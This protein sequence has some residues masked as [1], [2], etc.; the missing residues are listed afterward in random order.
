MTAVHEETARQRALDVYHVVDSLPDTAFDDIGRIASILCAAPIALVSLIDRDRQW[1]KARTGFELSETRR[2][3][4]FCDHAIRTPGALMEVPDAVD[5]ARFA[6]NP[7]VTGSTGIRFYAGMPLITPSGAA[8]GT[9]C[10]LDREPRTLSDAQRE[11]LAS[12]ARLTMN[13]LE[14]RHR[15]RALE[16]SIWLASPAD[17]DEPE[18]AP[19]VRS[20]GRTIVIFEVQGLADAVA[21]LGERHVERAFLGL[22]KTLESSLRS[23]TGDNLSRATGSPEFIVVLQGDAREDTLRSLREVVHAFA[24]ESALALASGSATSESGEES[25]E[26]LFLRADADLS[27]DKDAYRRT[28]QSG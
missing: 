15:E 23:G 8:I 26:E 27:L 24:A 6:T 4:A 22:E 14:A 12:L 18:T 7:L 28:V 11:G 19:T 3:D 1:L 9:V 17:P 10:V 20:R 13:L 16:R 25:V 2:E 21:R 5:D